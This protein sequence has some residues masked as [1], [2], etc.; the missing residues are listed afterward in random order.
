MDAQHL[1][2]LEQLPPR[3]HGPLALLASICHELAGDGGLG[4]TAFG[5]VVE[6]KHFDPHQEA[7]R[8]VLVLRSDDLEVLRSLADSGSQLQGQG[9]AAPLIMTPEYIEASLD[10]FPLEF[11]EIQQQHVTVDGH[12]YFD[13]IDPEPGHVRLQAEREMK[14]LLIGMRQGL[15]RSFNNRK[16]IR[17]LET[18]VASK[19]LLIFRGMLWLNGDTKSYPAAGMV[20]KIEELVERPLA[21]VPRVLGSGKHDHWEEFKLLYDDLK[22]VLGFIEQ[23]KPV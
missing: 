5:S 23:W 11:L 21:A 16:S 6:G 9:I 3:L 2:G 12:D 10:A 18:D 22:A 20:A 13:D 17:M 7:M 19:L 14:G 4:L 15:L 1:K 8:S